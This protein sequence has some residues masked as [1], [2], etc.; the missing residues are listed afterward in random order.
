MAVGFVSEWD[1]TSDASSMRFE[2]SARFGDSG[3]R[4]I[5]LEFRERGKDAQHEF[6]EGSSAQSLGRHDFQCDVV[7]PQFFKQSDEVPQIPRQPVEAMD[8]ELLDAAGPDDAQQSVQRRPVKCRARVPFVVK[9]FLDED[10]AQRTLGLN[11]RPALV[12]LDLAGGEIS[13]WLFRLAGVDGA[14]NRR[15]DRRREESGAQNT[16][17]IGDSGSSRTPPSTN[18]RFPKTA[19]REQQAVNRARASFGEVEKVANGE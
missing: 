9:P 8:Y 5:S 10:E 14:A 19:N 7:I 13:V 11:E 6:V 15:S 4:E 2:M 16:S 17:S 12:E 18:D 1:S 3:G